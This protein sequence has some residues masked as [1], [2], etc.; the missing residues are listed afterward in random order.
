MLDLTTIDI[1]SVTEE[2]FYSLLVVFNESIRLKRNVVYTYQ[3]TTPVQPT[4]EEPDPVPITT[5]IYFYINK[6][7][8]DININDL[9]LAISSISVSDYGFTGERL[10]LVTKPFRV[11]TGIDAEAIGFDDFEEIINVNKYD[12]LRSVS[13]EDLSFAKDIFHSVGLENNWPAVTSGISLAIKTIVED[14]EVSFNDAVGEAELE[15][16]LNS[17]KLAITRLFNP[18]VVPDEM[19]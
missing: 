19:I 2:K 3:I 10:N 14:Y 1:D 5:D 12:Y 8:V 11:L 18:F 9:E 13:V 16:I 6:P 7:F 17:V 4:I 15:I